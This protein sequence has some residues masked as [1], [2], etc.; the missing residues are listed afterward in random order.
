MDDKPSETSE[1]G[2][3]VIEV[4]KAVPVY[5]DAIQPLAKQSGKAL[6]TMGRTVNALLLPIKGM[7]WG[8]EQ[9]EEF[10]S[11]KVGGKLEKTPKEQLIS[12]KPSVVAPALENLRFRADEDDIQELYANLIA[13][14]MDKRSA[15]RIY[16]SFVE[17]L[18]QLTPDEAKLLRYIAR[19]DDGIPSHSHNPRHVGQERQ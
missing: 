1:I 13:S 5:Q 12:P 16:P 6:E 17:I 18:K 8:A 4:V 2:K 14:A 7:I 19:Y 9:L 3:A 10:L 15:Q 11:R